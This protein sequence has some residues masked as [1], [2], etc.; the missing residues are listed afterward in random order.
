MSKYTTVESWASRL[1]FTV[2]K[3]HDGYIWHSSDESA[4]NHCQTAGEVVEKI[5]QRI[6]DDWGG[7]G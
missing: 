7:E 6:R 2:E 5:L 1:G 4:L 3:S